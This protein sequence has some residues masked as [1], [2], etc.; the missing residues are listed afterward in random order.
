MDSSYLSALSF[1]FLTYVYYYYIKV[2]LVLKGASEPDK[3][4]GYASYPEYLSDNNRSLVIYFLMVVTSQFAMNLYGV[5]QKCGGTV[6][7][8]LL[9]S[10]M[11]TVVPWTLMFGAIMGLLVVYPGLKGAFADV[12]GY[13]AISSEAN[14]ILSDILNIDD[15]MKLAKN[16]SQSK[17]EEQ[18]T[19][20]LA[21]AVMKLCGNKGIMINTMNPENFINIWS[22]LKPLLKQEYKNGNKS[23]ELFKKKQELFALVVKKDN[24]GEAFWYIYT[25]LLLM[26]IVSYNLSSR[27][28]DKDL[29]KMKQE[30]ADYAQ[31]SADIKAKKDLNQSKTYVSS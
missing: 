12:V 10:F 9:M 22:V 1:L 2:S 18:E 6:G 7:K 3:L 20:T 4:S 26:S 28:C 14:E 13:F 27:A 16:T 30:Q 23:E 24:I 31:K 29:A 8:N 5:I 11:M 25:G 15:D 19:Q 17:E 21:Q